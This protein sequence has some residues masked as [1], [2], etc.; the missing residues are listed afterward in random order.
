MA[1]NIT[2]RSLENTL[3]DD[4]VNPIVNKILKAIENELGAQ[5]REK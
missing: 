2:F 4:E 3:K 1:Y 5:L